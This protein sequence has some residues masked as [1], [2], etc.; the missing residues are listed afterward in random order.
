MKKLLCVMVVLLACANV[1]MAQNDFHFKTFLELMNFQAKGKSLDYYHG[2]AN[3]AGLDLI[4][5]TNESGEIYYVF[6]KGVS[7]KKGH[8]TETY[9][10]LADS[11]KLLN[12]DLTENKPGK[13]TPITITLIFP[14]RDAQQRFRNEGMK[15]GC[16][17]NNNIYSTDIDPTWSN[18]DGITYALFAGAHSWRYI[19]FYEKDDMYM[20][21]FLF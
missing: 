5:D 18:V 17:V 14:D 19:Y 12:F 13:Y 3:K 7:Y 8:M 1:T 16:K 2:L 21:T 6:S 11:P 10:K 20:C 4:Y 15:I 9:T